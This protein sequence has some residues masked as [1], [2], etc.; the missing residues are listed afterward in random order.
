[1]KSKNKE[2]IKKSFQDLLK[3]SNKDEQWEHDAQILM[4]Q[5]LGLVDEKMDEEGISKKALAEKINTSTAYITQLFRGDKKLNFKTLA[6]LQDALGLKFEV[7]NRE[8]IAQQKQVKDFLHYK[9][10]KSSSSTYDK[11]TAFEEINEDEAYKPLAA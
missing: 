4:F 11:P 10:A 7:T 1:M 5:F 6:K 2:A 8:K 9:A 3:Y